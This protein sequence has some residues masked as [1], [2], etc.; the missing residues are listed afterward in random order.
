MATRHTCDRCGAEV[1]DRSEFWFCD[2]QPANPVR[3][4]RGF[5]RMELCRRCKERVVVFLMEAD[6]A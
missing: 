4:A 2:L 5:R 3:D 1:R 6:R